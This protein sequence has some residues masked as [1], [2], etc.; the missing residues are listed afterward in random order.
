LREGVPGQIG[1]D[2]AGDDADRAVTAMYHEHYRSLVRVA[3]LLVPDAATAD[4]VVQDCFVAMH[5][6]WQRQAGADR[7]LAYLRRSVVRRCRTAR[8]TAVARPAG[9]SAP[10]SAAEPPDADPRPPDLIMTLRSL[11][12]LQREVLVL[13]CYAGWSRDQIASA[14]SITRGTADRLADRAMASVQA[15]LRGTAG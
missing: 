15:A 13:R 6:A 4:V 11:P 14:M 12:A 2:Q 8:R 7:A 1:D 3:A 9:G 5:A 10:A